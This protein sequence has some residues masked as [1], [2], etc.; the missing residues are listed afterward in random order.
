MAEIEI[1]PR[2][3]Q[4]EACAPE[5]LSDVSGSDESEEEEFTSIE[6]VPAIPVQELVPAIPVQV[7]VPVRFPI[8]LLVL[9][10]DISGIRFGTHLPVLV[11]DKGP[12]RYKIRYYNPGY[13]WY[14]WIPVE[15]ALIA[16]SRY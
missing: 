7:P 12:N 10:C 2:P 13:Q 16:T 1:V 9:I 11:C 3:E 15:S 5:D 4:R 8:P 6:L 14:Q